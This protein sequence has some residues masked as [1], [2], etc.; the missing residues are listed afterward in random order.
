MLYDKYFSLADTYEYD[1]GAA[2]TGTSCPASAPAGW[3][4]RTHSTYVT[5]GYDTVVTAACP[6]GTPVPCAP[7]SNHMRA[8]LQEADVY[9]P[10]G[11]IAKTTYAYDAAA[12]TTETS[13]NGFAAPTHSDLGNLTSK[14]DSLNLI[15]PLVT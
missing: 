13:P 1:F 7:N 11:M 2:V 3:L 15:T 12:P 14:T 9:N 8:L 4:R 5:N 10:S 6:T